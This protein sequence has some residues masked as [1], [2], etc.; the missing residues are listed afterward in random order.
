MAQTKKMTG[1]VISREDQS[2]MIG[3]S[4]SIKGTS[5]GTQVKPDGTWSLDVNLGEILIIR[6]TGYLP[7]EIRVTD[8]TDLTIKLETDVQKMNE[9]VV[10]GYGTQSRGNVTNAIAKLDNTVLANAPRANIGSALQGSVSGLQVVNSTGQPG[11]TPVIIL[12]GGA[13][14]NNPG[15]PLVLVD[16]AIRPYNDVPSEDIA[17]VEVLKDASATAIYGARA[18]NGV[19]LITTKQG[20]A[21]IAQV[22]YKFTGGYNQRRD[23]YHY[24]GAK[25]YIYYTRLGYFNAGRTLSQVNS[26]R[27]L[28]LST[29][30]AD[31]ASF[32]IRPFNNTTATLLA[33]GWDTVGDPYGG[34]IIFKDHGGEIE[35]ILFR[36]T[37]TQDHYVNVTG[38]HDKG[39]YFASFDYYKEDG[40]IVGSGYKRFSG[41]VNGSYKIK[42]NLEVGTGVTMSTSSQIG[43]IGGEVNSLYRSLAIWPTFN[44]WLDSA[45]T[46]PNP[47]NGA[48][49]GN[50][51]Y[52]L[53]KLQRNNEENRVSANA[54]LKW[55]ILP[56]LYFRGTA[57]G[58]YYE[59]IKQSFQQATQTYAN[60][61]AN[62]PSYSSTSRDAIAYY[63]RDFQQQYNG[64]LNYTK[65]IGAKHHI[66]LMAGAEYFGV[67]SLAMQVYGKNAPT[68]GIPTA[69]ASTVFNPGDNYSTRTEYRILSTFSRLNYDYDQRYLLSMTF[70]QDAVSSLSRDHRSGLFPGVSLGWNM[71]R[72]AFY[73]KL[74]I[75]GWVSTLKPRVSYGVNG[76]VAGLSRYE[77]Q[78]VYGLQ[79]NYNGNA[80]FLNTAVTNPELR[81]EKSKTTDI[82]LDLGFLDNRVTVLF[83]YYNRKTSDLITNLQLPSYIGFDQL[84]TNLGTYQNK[85]YEI[86]VNANVLRRSNGVNL[87][88]GANA[89][90]VKNKILQLPYNGNEHN[91]QGGL[92][93]YD[94]A[95][96][97]VIWVGGLQ[98]GQALGDVYGYQQVSVFKD[99]KEVNNIAGNRY[100]A[101]AKTSGPN[102]AAGA[103]G[104]IT[105][106]DVNWLDKDRNDTIDS[107]DQ[108][109]LGNIFPKWTGGFS[110]NL[111]WKGISL[112]SRF[113]FAI[114]HTIY[115]DL[116]ARTLGN[117]Q[118]TFNYTEL[119]KQAWSPANMVTDIPKVYFADQVAG[120][121]QNYTRANNGN[122]VLNGNNSRFY[123]KGN[124]LACREITLSYELPKN[125]LKSSRVLSQAR[126]YGSA[127]NLF[128]IT[129]FSGP[130]PEP[131]VDANGRITGIYQGTYPTPKTFVL[132]AQ[133]SF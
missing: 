49:D 69:N 44:P 131:P 34:T 119:Q 64:I 113:D 14:I 63:A 41:D 106:G 23:G 38:G 19:I 17:S 6:Y 100:D 12:R 105:P 9:V 83:D 68:D 55:D 127:N 28:G 56:G 112:Y 59:N 107:R 10:V 43:A 72:E 39:K 116:L 98:E 36:N 31:L 118:G 21:G 45:K 27:G 40:V 121:K 96:G 35:N 25:D 115:N 123:E 24:L 62:P 124:Y 101:I 91:R 1:R 18:N 81:W 82:G 26:S 61:F 22:S 13:S 29:N 4:I 46:Q 7:Q 108:V 32:D 99:D 37:Y 48:S 86:E 122:P 60:I 95:S 126:I 128:Y 30:P 3:A 79:T 33:N 20:K 111:S 50:P 130:T 42:P 75:D 5:R 67:K 80:G 70:R 85:G 88:L 58:Y 120:S 84:K 117:Y 51:L 114:G 47:G 52:W 104:S 97:K 89:S 11:A 65:T 71:H 129:R 87:T 73:H 78:G 77:V 92:Q 2:P 132:G 110:A 54:W 103:N 109:Y 57:N 133:V 90:F 15:A 66:N 94:P 74:G 125:W 53:N 8:K 76:N 93:I 102:L 16:G